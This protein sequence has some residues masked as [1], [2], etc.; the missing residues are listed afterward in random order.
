MFR[1]IRLQDTKTAEVD[2]ALKTIEEASGKMDFETFFAWCQRRYG[3]GAGE[4]GNEDN[5]EQEKQPVRKVPAKLPKPNQLC[6]CGSGKKY[7]KCCARIDKEQLASAEK[8][9]REDKEQRRQKKEQQLADA[10][11]NL[12]MKARAF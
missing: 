11:K 6:H 8:K 2:V 7:K 1:L 4:E 12:A 3:E 5:E 9:R 10:K